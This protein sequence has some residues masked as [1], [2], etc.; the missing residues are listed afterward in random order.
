[1]ENIKKIDSVELYIIKLPL[2][3]PFENSLK[4]MT[5]KMALI[6]KL[7]LDN[8]SGWGEC[9][10]DIVPYYFSETIETAKHITEDFLLPL[11]FEQKNISVDGIGKIFSIIRGHN[12]AKAMV[13]N[14]LLDL[15][16]KINHMPLYELIG[17]VEKNIMSGISLGIKTNIAML[18]TQIADSKN[19]NYHRIKIK[20]KKGMELDALDVI[21]K[22]FS[23]TSFAVDANGD[24]SIEDIKILKKIDD[25]NLSMIEQPL[26]YN[27]L[28]EHSLLHK[29]LKTPICLDESIMNYN[30]LIS[31]VALK[32][33]NIIN[34]KQGRVGGL[35]IAKKMQNYCMKN[36]IK[37]WSGGM[38][39]T[40]IG[41]AFNIHLQ[42]LSGFNMPGDTSETSRYFNEDIVSKPVTL[43]KKGYI[44]I[45]KGFG[46]GV[47]IN[48]KRLNKYKI[49]YKYII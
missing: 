9:T 16:A 1:M 34:I 27:D 22:T 28:Y 37:V 42:T 2:V 5:H 8:L 44:E 24:Y 46:I 6:I 49:F 41:R 17:G 31:A 15:Y 20:I 48:T 13:E 36:G 29:S 32:S 35:L 3:R 4:I 19:K 43:D 7:N 12:M 25:Y 38:L 21:C 11:L 39:E 23:D 45:P 14:A 30:S 33:C 26:N 10:A 47:G 40:G 18:I